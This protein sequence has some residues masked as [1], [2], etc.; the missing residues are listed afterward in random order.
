MKYDY[1]ENWAVS[2]DRLSYEFCSEEPGGLISSLNERFDI[3]GVK[4]VSGEFD[5]ERFKGNS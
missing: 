1:Y 2:D 3:W 5:L 4:N